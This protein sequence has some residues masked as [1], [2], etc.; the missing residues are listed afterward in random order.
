M[1]SAMS[2][3]A[4]EAAKKA[5][6]ARAIGSQNS[7]AKRTAGPVEQFFLLHPFVSTD[8]PEYQHLSQQH[9]LCW[10]EPRL[11]VPAFVSEHPDYLFTSI[12]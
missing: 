7:G 1:G 9:N 6:S 10:D 4:S 2:R 11:F 8:H 12:C 5:F 3:R